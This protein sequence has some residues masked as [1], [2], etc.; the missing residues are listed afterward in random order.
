VENLAPPTECR[1][2]DHPSRSESQ[3][4]LLYSHDKEIENDYVGVAEV[5][6]E[7][8][9]LVVNHVGDLPIDI[10]MILKQMSLKWG[11]KVRCERN[12]FGI[13][14]LNMLRYH[15]YQIPASSLPAEGL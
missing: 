15:G 10:G 2:P 5:R 1:S 14:P 3:Y 4:L 6:I 7:C 8:K 11:V 12:W 9:I 13:V